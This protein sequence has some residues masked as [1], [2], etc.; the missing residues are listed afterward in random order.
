MLLSQLWL[1]GLLAGAVV[2]IGKVCA[3]FHPVQLVLGTTTKHG[4]SEDH[5]TVVPMGLFEAKPHQIILEG[6]KGLDA[7]VPAEKVS[8]EGGRLSDEEGIAS[9]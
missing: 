4:M 7:R 2:L 6:R 8:L 1:F 5:R 3:C 9:R